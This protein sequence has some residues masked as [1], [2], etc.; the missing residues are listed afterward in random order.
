MYPNK[1]QFGARLREKARVPINRA[2]RHNYPQLM[3]ELNLQLKQAKVIA[4]SCY[5]WELNCKTEGH[6]G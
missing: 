1:E 2:V 6:R 3:E 5:L 4:Q